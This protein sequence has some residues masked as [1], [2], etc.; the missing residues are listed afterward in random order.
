MEHLDSAATSHVGHVRERNEDAFLFDPERGLFVVA[1]G[2]GGHPAGD[3]ASRVAVA[4]LDRLLDAAALQAS[5]DL[6]A[7]LASALTGAHEAVIGAARGHPE[8]R[9]MGTTAVVAFVP[10]DGATAAVA[11]AGDSRAY[12][13]R[14][15][16]LERLTV[17]HVAPSFY[18]RSLTQALG[19]EGPL[20]P[21]AASVALHHGDRLLLCSDGL[22]DMIDDERIADIAAAGAPAEATCQ[23]LVEAALDRG[24]IDNVTVIVVDV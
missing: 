10:P 12:L 14:D 19:T 13:V 22:T 18:G 17:D 16:A 9:Q 23:R 11:H 4:A 7:A 5:D 2:L 8:R 1:D 3:V 24:G 20:A 21:D 6:P 15:G